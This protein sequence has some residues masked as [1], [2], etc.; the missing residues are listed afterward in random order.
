VQ[1]LAS[2][3]SCDSLGELPL[4][5]ADGKA[6]AGDAKSCAKLVNMRIMASSSPQVR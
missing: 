2:Q 4:P 6:A 3:G 5:A 1:R